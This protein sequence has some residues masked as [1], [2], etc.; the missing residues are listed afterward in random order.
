LAYVLNDSSIVFYT[1]LNASNAYAPFQKRP[2][3]QWIWVKK[4][5]FRIWSEDELREKV[6]PEDVSYLLSHLPSFLC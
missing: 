3:G 5:N 4:R 1:H 6:K 2:N